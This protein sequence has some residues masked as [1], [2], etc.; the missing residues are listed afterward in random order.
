VPVT[1]DGGTVTVT[2]N[3]MLEIDG[4]ATLAV[5][6]GRDERTIVVRLRP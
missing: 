5:S 1:I 4:E 2:G 3:G 6:G